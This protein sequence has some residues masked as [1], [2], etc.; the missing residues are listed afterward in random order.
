MNLMLSSLSPFP[1][2][3]PVHGTMLPTFTGLSLPQSELSAN[4]LTGMH[5]LVDTTEDVFR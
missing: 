5:T 1:F 3:T 2:W 4:A